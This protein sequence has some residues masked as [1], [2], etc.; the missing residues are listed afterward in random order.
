MRT[1]V[2]L[3]AFAVGLVAV[4]ALGAGIG[5]AVGPAPATVEDE[6]P[7]P[8]GA[9]VVSSESGYRLVALSPLAADGGPFSFTILDREGAP[10]MGFTPLHERALHLVVVNRELTTFH[11]VHP[12]LGADGTWSVEL[13]ALEPGSYRA[14]ADFHVEDGPRLALG[15]DLAIAGAYRPTAPPAPSTSAAV[16][17]YEVTLESEQHDGGL[18]ELSFTVRRDGAVV[19]DLQPYLGAGGH[20]IALRADDLAYAHVHPMDAHDAG[21]GTIR[22]EATLPSEGRYRLF[23]DFQHGGTVHTASFSFDQGTVTGSAPVMGH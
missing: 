20:L 11:H 16:D 5:A 4:F 10:V 15:I 6:A 19:T 14:I 7:A 23:L 18:D 12:A 17:G 3:L 9:G 8:L 21:S 1:P 13:P 22:F 2:K